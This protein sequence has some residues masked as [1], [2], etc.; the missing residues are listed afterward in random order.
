MKRLLSILFLLVINS[1]SSTLKASCTYQYTLALAHTSC[2]ASNGVVSITNVSG[3]TAPYTFTFDNQ[4]TNNTGSFANIA[5]GSHI[6]S[7]TDA[8]NCV[9]Y[10]PT[11]IIHSSTAIT[12]VAVYSLATS[13]G[14]NNGAITL[15]TVTGG[16]PPYTY[17]LNTQPYVSTN[18]FTNLNPG[19]YMVQVKDNLGC[20][21]QVPT[22][23]IAQ[24]YGMQGVATTTI[25]T[26]CDSANG[27]VHINGMIG[28]TPPFL[29]NFNNQG[30][31]N[32]TDYYSLSVGS[33]SLQVLDS[34]NCLFNAALV[35]VNST[36]GIQMVYT[37]HENATCNQQNGKIVIDSVV[38]GHPPYSFNVNNIGFVS[39]TSFNQLSAG[40]YT[41]LV[42]DSMGCSY[43]APN[44][45]IANDVIGNGVPSI[46]IEA[47]KELICS[48]A[49]TRI[50]IKAI[51]HQGVTPTYQWYMVVFGNTQ[52]IS[53]AN[54]EELLVPPVFNGFSVNGVQFYVKMYSSDNCVVNNEAVSNYVN[55]NVLNNTVD[56]TTDFSASPTQVSNSPYEVTFTN[57]SFYQINRSY[58]WSFGD[59][60]IYEGITPPKHRYALPGNYTVSLFVKDLSSGCTD[61]L[62]REGYVQ[63]SGASSNCN[64]TINVFPSDSVTLCYLEKKWIYVQSDAPNASYQ[65]FKNG[66][67]LGGEVNDSLRVNSEGVYSAVVY[68]NQACPMPS[69]NIHVRMS[70]VPS[71]IPEVA[72]SGSIGDCSSPTNMILNASTGFSNYRWNTGSNSQSIQVHEAGLY[73]VTA[74]DVFGCVLHSNLIRLNSASIPVT[75]LCMASFD[76]LANRNRVV[77]T[78]NPTWINATDS[79]FVFDYQ[80]DDTYHIIKK[81]GKASLGSVLSSSSN[82]YVKSYDYILASSDT[83]GNKVFS[84]QKRN[85]IFLQ[86]NAGMG[87]Y[88]QLSWSAYRDTL[89]F[90]YKIYRYTVGSVLCIDSVPSNKL[91]YIDQTS[92]DINAQ[93][94][95]AV[96]FADACTLENGSSYIGSFSNAAY[97]NV[98]AIPMQVNIPESSSDAVISC[99]PNPSATVCTLESSEAF[100]GYT[101]FDV[102]GRTVLQESF[103]QTKTFVV[104]LHTLAAGMYHLRLQ[105]V[106]SNV[107]RIVKE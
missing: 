19:N 20:T 73:Q 23:S 14:S 100:N 21:F 12:N 99:Y 2:G 39:A 106:S 88:R 4:Q 57:T 48:N 25:S 95:V 97:N 52:L 69:P 51:E 54:S 1:L 58:V 37:S 29:Y 16:Q 83:C 41:L 77:W 70:Y 33:Y 66:M 32:T 46:I 81:Q 92:N 98:V 105:G 6:A 42:N 60:S 90:Y 53:G 64:D 44:E 45:F 103:A 82:P 28:G 8:T 11:I 84:E 49:S 27:E 5:A 65:W 86:V 22:I 68:S 74:Q 38:G 47:E 79:F 30:F 9:F 78:K 35:G 50:R 36:D 13:C 17:K 67:L 43:Q 71:T 62:F 15:S 63:V 26:P 75:N 72:S 93:Y 104:D 55:I 56:Q 61:T 24:S 101:L 40:V 102:Y 7:I 87:V 59:G 89:P 94:K 76:S 18:V 31:S 34:S 80:N 96:Y 107:V 3:G 10:L 85:N 91:Y